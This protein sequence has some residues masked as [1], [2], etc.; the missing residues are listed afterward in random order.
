MWRI[1]S[2]LA[3]AWRM[4]AKRSLSHWRLLSSVVLGV[5]LASAIMAG[6]VIYFGALRELA[7]KSALADHSQTELDILVKGK[8]SP[9]RSKGYGEVAAV[10]TEEIDSHAAW[11]L[12]DS[13]RGAKSPPFFLATADKKDLVGEDN[14][15]TYFVFEQDALAHVTFVTGGGPPAERPLKSLDTSPEIEAMVP[16]GAAKLFGVRAGDRMVA[17]P[18][19]Q[20]AAVPYVTVVISGV[21]QRNDPDEDFWYM[22]QSALKAPTGELFRTLPFYVTEQSLMEVLGRLYP[23]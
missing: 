14:A 20:D 6:T 2:G 1:A 8:W 23:R 10:V 18:T 9:S 15:R 21:F 19:W 3:T 11:L 13:L 16:D 12:T 17:A 22:D 7:L 5:V 4:A